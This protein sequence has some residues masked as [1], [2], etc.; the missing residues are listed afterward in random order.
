MDY[1]K[2]KAM[3]WVS[4]AVLAGGLVSAVILFWVTKIE[5]EVQLLSATVL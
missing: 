1:W 3:P 4:L 5:S 2:Q